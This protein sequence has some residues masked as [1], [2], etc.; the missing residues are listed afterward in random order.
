MPSANARPSTAVLPLPILSELMQISTE[1]LNVRAM[2]GRIAE[3]LGRYFRWDFVALVSIDRARDRFVCEAV[4]TDLATAIAPGYSRPLG[5]GVVG[6][7]AATGQAVLVGDASL[8]ENFVH[9]LPGGQSELCVPVMHRGEMLAVLNVESLRKHAFDEDLSLVQVIAGHIAGAIAAARRVEELR[10]QSEL[11]RIVADFSRGA[12]EAADLDALLAHV[13]EFLGKRFN[14]LEA[15]VLLEGDLRDHLEVMAHRGASPQISYRGKQWPVAE[16]IVGRCFRSREV[17]FIPDVRLATD[18]AV[19]NPA[20]RAE[21][22]V[23]IRARGRVFG[24]L[25][26]EADN[27]AVFADHERLIFT[28]LADQ[29][30]GAIHMFALN[31]RLLQSQQQ[32]ERRGEELSSTR[33]HLRRAVVKLDRRAVREQQAGCLTVA[34]MRRQLSAEL[35]AV[36]RGGRALL[37]ALIEPPSGLQTDEAGWRQWLGTIASKQPDA[38]LCRDTDKR[39]LLALVLTPE[40]TLEDCRKLLADLLSEPAGE[41]ALRSLL[42]LVAAGSVV[43]TGALLESLDRQWQALPTR[44]QP[45]VATVFRPAGPGRSRRKPAAPAPAPE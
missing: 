9:T 19:V 37:V 14:A 11:L 34:A 26:L 43:S 18:Y 27:A 36:A 24:V 44:P 39:L 17:V 3:A 1:D 8:H 21:M 31:R 2:M 15:T 30:A 32:A 29:V 35:R 33:E 13:L 20:V 16:G 12:L 6:E 42:Q 45:P 5:S 25:N 28:T 4:H 7:V 22:A 38:L 41:Q 40:R 23:P 10:R